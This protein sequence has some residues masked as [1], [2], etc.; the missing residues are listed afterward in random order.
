MEILR[1]VRLECRRRNLSPRTE[2]TYCFCIKK[3]LLQINKEEFQVTKRD[4]TNYLNYITE[5]NKSGSTINVYFNAIKFM[6]EDVMGKKL[7]WKKKFSKTPKKL[8][9]F[10][11]KDEVINLINNIPNE[12]HKLAIELLYGAGLRVSELLNLKIKDFQLESNYGWVRNGKGKKDRLFI[13]PF[14]LKNKI[15]EQI[16][17]KSEE[18]YLISRKDNKQLSRMTI[19]AIIKKAKM[20][21]KINKKIHPHTLRHSFA[22]HLIQN[23]YDV[24]S[25]QSLLGHNSS[26]TTMIYI[27]MASP[28]LIN[29]KSPLDSIE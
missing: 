24:N 19:Q 10:L 23:G 3:F 2:E 25:V 22:T 17:N 4:V 6:L 16:K 26:Q 29:V 13:I 28:N 5:K 8:P 20:K 12:K 7:I 9:I 27:H 21:A 15:K 14:K 11:T 1:K 18:V